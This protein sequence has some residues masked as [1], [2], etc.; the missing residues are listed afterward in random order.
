MNK[1]V[2]ILPT[3]RKMIL[4][5]LQNLTKTEKMKRFSLQK[6][7][8]RMIKLFKLSKTK[9]VYLNIRKNLNR[10][11]SLKRISIYHKANEGTILYSLSP[12]SS[13]RANFKSKKVVL[14]NK[15]II[16]PKTSKKQHHIFSLN[17]IKKSKIQ[18]SSSL[19]DTA[20][21]SK[22]SA[23][24]SNELKTCNLWKPIVSGFSRREMKHNI[25]NIFLPN[26]LN[27]QNTG[28]Y[29]DAVKFF[30]K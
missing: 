12:R 24:S 9:L 19:S 11:I 7:R 18:K 26:N 3:Y 21:C 23:I 2:E 1:Q 22:R 16:T 13:K 6:V 27:N 28:L 14:A 4:A 30:Y 5:T 15:K 17:S 10:L 25:T 20:S 29:T 8:G